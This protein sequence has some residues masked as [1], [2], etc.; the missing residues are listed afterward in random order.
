VQRRLAAAVAKDG[1]QRLHQRQ[2]LLHGCGTR[3]RPAVAVLPT[4]PPADIAARIAA[5][6]PHARQPIAGSGQGTD[7]VPADARRHDLRWRATKAAPLRDGVLEDRHQV[8]A[9]PERVPEKV[10]AVAAALERV[11]PTEQGAVRERARPSAPRGVQPQPAAARPF[12]DPD[13]IGMRGCTASKDGVERIALDRPVAPA[14]HR[15]HMPHDTLGRQP[16][17][18]PVRASEQHLMGLGLGGGDGVG[19]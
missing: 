5:F 12:D 16:A 3:D 2:P 9:E 4:Q 18:P 6:P 7:G 17:R 13:L 11:K 10:R 1:E 8:L 14:R 15:E 19:R